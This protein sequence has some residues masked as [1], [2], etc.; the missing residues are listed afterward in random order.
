MGYKMYQC[1]FFLLIL[2]NAVYSDIEWDESAALFELDNLM[3][4]LPKN[5]VIP[6]RF[7]VNGPV[8]RSEGNDLLQLKLLQKAF[9]KFENQDVL[10]SFDKKRWSPMSTL[11][12]YSFVSRIALDKTKKPVFQISIDLD[13][14]DEAKGELLF[15]Q[16]E[17]AE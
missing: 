10:M 17:F 5:S 7:T 2:M 12:Q 13:L 15:L 6:L 11:F 9:L 4:T 3:I 1:F 8:L 14:S 16:T